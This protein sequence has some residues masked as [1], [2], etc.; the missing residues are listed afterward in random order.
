MN[1]YVIQCIALSIA[2]LLAQA[3]S[4]VNHFRRGLTIYIELNLSEFRQ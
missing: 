1:W 2:D 4:E 3:P